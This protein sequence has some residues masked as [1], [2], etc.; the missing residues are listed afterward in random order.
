MPI[1]L[2]TVLEP[3]AKLLEKDEP[4][5]LVVVGAGISAGATAAPYATWLGLLHHGIEYLVATE[6]FT[7]KRGK[8]LK[9]SLDAAFSPFDLKTA[10]HHADLIEQNLTTPDTTAFAL[11]LGAAFHD[12]KVVAGREETLDALSDLQQ[13]GAVLLT[14][15]Y[16]TLLSEV[17]GLPPVTWEEHAEFL[18]VINRQR[19]GILHIHGHWQRP[20]S[21]VLGRDSHDRIVGDQDLQDAFKSLW[22]EWSWIYVGCCDGLDDPNLGRLLE[23]GKRWGTG[24]LPHYFLAKADKADALAKRPD[25]PVNLVDVG[26]PDHTDL[27]RVL[28]HSLLPAARCWPFWPGRL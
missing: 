5:V 25:K 28:L 13:G 23:W 10:L 8:E 3:L 18:R 27:P 15:N 14:T 11:W 12:F 24:A 21:V 2:P 7:D 1:P 17:T 16:D 6:A 26:Y 4:K 9:A 19:L 20:T 22:L